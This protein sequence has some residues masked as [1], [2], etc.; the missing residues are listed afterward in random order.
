MSLNYQGWKWSLDTS[1]SV[2]G[3]VLKKVFMKN[4]LFKEIPIQLQT[5]SLNWLLLLN[6]IV[7]CTVFN[8][9][10]LEI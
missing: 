5:V 4:S 1:I 9:K 8:N 2:K 10:M 6:V 3:C 7:E